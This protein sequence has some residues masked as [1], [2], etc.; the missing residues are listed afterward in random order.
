MICVGEAGD[1]WQQTPAKILKKYDVTAIDKDG[2][3]VCTPKPDNEVDCH[4]VGSTTTN[5]QSEFCVIGQWGETVG[6]LKN[7]Q[8]G[9]VGD[10]IC[11]NRT[12]LA[13]VWVVRKNLFNNTYVIK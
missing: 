10:F 1:V 5:M 12:D 3:M 8:R 6:P 7:V 9:V 11:R 13:D 2:W 4:E